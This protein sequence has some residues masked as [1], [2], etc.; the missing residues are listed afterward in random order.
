MSAIL[1]ISTNCDLGNFG[2]L[3]RSDVGNLSSFNS[4]YGL[5]GFGSEIDPGFYYP[6][7]LGALLRLKAVALI[8][9]G[10]PEW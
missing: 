4:I 9:I 7:L 8:P 1:A 3:D 2:D 5:N 10:P 6:C